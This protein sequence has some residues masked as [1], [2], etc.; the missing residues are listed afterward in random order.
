MWSLIAIATFDLK[1][2]YDPLRTSLIFPIKAFLIALVYT[3]LFLGGLITPVQ[4]EENFLISKKKTTSNPNSATK[5]DTFLYRQIGVNF[6]CRARMADIEFPK[7]IGIASATFADVI[8][9][10]HGGFVQEL[11][12]EKLTPK[13]L[14]LSAEIQIIEGAI[15]FCPNNVPSDVKDKF[16]EFV[17]NKG[18]NVNK[19]NKNKSK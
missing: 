13:Q 6:L 4:S 5:Q 15:K 2:F 18:K 12:D 10:K 3:P 7:A 9:Q 11:P 19:N 8:S 16:E 14:Y 17:R 1:F